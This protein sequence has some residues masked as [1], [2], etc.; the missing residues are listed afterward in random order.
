VASGVRAGRSL[1]RRRPPRGLFEQE[2]GRRRPQRPHRHRPREAPRAAVTEEIV[3]EFRFSRC[4]CLQSSL[5]PSVIRYPPRP[6]PLSRWTVPSLAPQYRFEP[7]GDSCVLQEGRI[8]L[9]KMESIDIACKD[10]V[11]GMPSRRPI[12]EMMIPSVLDQI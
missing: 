1:R 7:S 3:P 5:H 6:S 2:A 9:S 4:S 10:A 11:K 8:G 12:V